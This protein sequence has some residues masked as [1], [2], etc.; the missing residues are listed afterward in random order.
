[1]DYARLRTL[2]DR[3]VPAAAPC[4]HGTRLGRRCDD[5]PRA[6]RRTEDRDVRLAIAI[7]VTGHGDVRAAAPRVDESGGARF[8]DVPHASRGTEDGDVGLPIAVVVG[9]HRD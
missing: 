6:C 3:D 2:R 8:D 5:E 1:M 9:L 7:I 4:E